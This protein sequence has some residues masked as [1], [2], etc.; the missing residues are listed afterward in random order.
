MYTFDIFRVPQLMTGLSGFHAETYKYVVVNSTLFKLC[1]THAPIHPCVL[2]GR[3]SI[4]IH[5]V[6]KNQLTLLHG[7]RAVE[8]YI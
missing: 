5:H 3:L 1:G 6:T 2:K 4:I 7:T 8:Q